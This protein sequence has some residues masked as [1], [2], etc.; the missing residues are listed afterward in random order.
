V[1]GDA[2]HNFFSFTLEG[3]FWK[4]PGQW[5]PKDIIKV[6]G[7]NLQRTEACTSHLLVVLTDQYDAIDIR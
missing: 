7:L 3:R 5:I 4:T 6:S 2:R 1:V